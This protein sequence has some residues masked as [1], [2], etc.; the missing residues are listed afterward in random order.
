ME[1]R[2]GH[3]FSKVRIYS[4]A[5]SARQ[6]DA[7][8][9][10]AFTLGQDVVF[11]SSSYAPGT[12]R[13]QQALA[14]ELTHVVQNERNPGVSR[15]GLAQPGDA[16]EREASALSR[17]VVA[18]ETVQVQAAP[19]ATVAPLFGWVEDAADWVGD[20]AQSAGSA[21]ADAAGSAWDTTKDIAS[22]VGATVADG[23]SAAWGG[24]KDAGSAIYSGMKQNA[25]YVRDGVKWAENGIDWLEDKA[26]G[27]AHWLAD[28]ADGIPVLEQLAQGGAWAVD[29]QAQLTGG[30]LKGATTLLGGVGQMVADPVDTVIG[31]EAMAEHVRPIP[32]MPN[33]LQVM[34]GLYNA[35]TTDATLSGEMNR[36]LNPMETMK[37]DMQ[38][39]KALVGGLLEPYKE[40]WDKGKYA[41]VGGRA[42]F[43][44]GSLFIGAGEANAGIKGAEGAAL[45]GDAARVAELGGDAARTAE[46]GGDAARVTDATDLA[47][48]AGEAEQAGKTL[49][50]VKGGPTGAGYVD[51][52]SPK[53]IRAYEEIA[54]MEGDAA[55]I[56]KQ[57]GVDEDIVAQVKEHLFKNEYDLPVVNEEAQSVAVKRGQFIPDE[58]IAQQ[59]KEAMG[60]FEPGSLQEAEFRRLMAH[61]YI[62]K[63]LMTEGMPYKALESFKD[64]P[65]GFYSYP[66]AEFHGAHDLAPATNALSQ[67]FAGWKSIFGDS[68]KPPSLKPDL[69]N[70]P[71]VLEQIKKMKGLGKP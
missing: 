17:Q 65:H 63:G 25:G 3:D 11:G 2:F 57:L 44:I 48:S 15:N 40:S 70:L 16:A 36:T 68:V 5:E 9:A 41:E 47:R 29:Q 24:V 4:D 69:S 39:G 1:P 34:H 60:G 51:Q 62:E 14:H 13:G 10:V 18:G 20:K 66:S 46:L 26:S 19:S 33:P 32:G 53:A 52:A 37:G 67:P 45:A 58:G 50:E 42:I 27:G 30:V 7:I 54:A 22:S 49:S 35:A 43:D 8:G 55:T 12:L 21:V 71:E 38:F 64:G 28:K 61:E 6:A 59:W 23:A 31:L 56:A